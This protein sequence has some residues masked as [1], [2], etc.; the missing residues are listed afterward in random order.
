VIDPGREYVIE[1]FQIDN[2]TRKPFRVLSDEESA[3]AAYDANT[4]LIQFNIVR[5]NPD[6]SPGDR[7]DDPSAVAM[8]IS[9]PRGLKHSQTRSL[10]PQEFKKRINALVHAPNGK[11][12]RGLLTGGAA[13]SGEIQNDEV[14]NQEFVRSINVR[15][16]KPKAQ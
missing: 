7:P 8:S 15:Y 11:K 13:V 14:K 3:Q 16:F 5:Q 4:G 10:T 9:L 6:K 2:N 12:S 1:G